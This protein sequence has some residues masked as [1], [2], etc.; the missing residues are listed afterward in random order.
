MASETGWHSLAPPHLR[1]HEWKPGSPGFHI[2]LYAYQNEQLMHC[3]K[4]TGNL[5]ECDNPVWQVLRLMAPF[6]LHKMSMHVAVSP[7]QCKLECALLHS[8]TEVLGYQDLWWEFQ[9][10]FSFTTGTLNLV[11]IMLTCAIPNIESKTKIQ[12]FYLLSPYITRIANLSI[13]WN[14]IAFVKKATNA[15]GMYSCSQM[16]CYVFHCLCCSVVIW[17]QA[18]PFLWRDPEPLKNVVFIYVI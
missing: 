18:G 11:I 15:L 1:D 9:R 17:R 7:L 5:S 10:N 13:N 14:S 4:S 3:G 16:C 12:H 2:I 6:G 8:I